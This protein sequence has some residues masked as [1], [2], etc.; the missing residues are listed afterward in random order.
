MM[1]GFPR[2]TQDEFDRDVRI[3][4]ELREWA[5]SISWH[6]CTLLPGTAY[7]DE[8]LASGRVTEE[9]YRRDVRS[10]YSFFFPVDDYNLSRVP[11]AHLRTAVA[12]F[13]MAW[14]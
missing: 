11:T 8:A 4:S 5:D 12:E 3:A 1:Y 14:R 6:F 13:G 2:Q 7:Y 10:G 9:R